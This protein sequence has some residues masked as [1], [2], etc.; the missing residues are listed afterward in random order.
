MATIVISGANRGIGLEL[1]RQLKGRGDRVIAPC[2]KSSEALEKIGAEVVEGVDVSDDVSVAKMA[3]RLKSEKIDILI[4]NAGI[5]TIESLENLDFKKMLR[6][7]DVNSLGPLRVTKAL[8]PNLQ[9]GSKVAIITSRMG[10][11]DDNGSGG[12][13][14]YRMSKV[15]VNM[16]G[17]CLANDLAARGITVAILHPG[18]V[19]TEMTGYSGIEPKESARG[20]IER[21]DSFS[22]PMSGAFFHANG[23]KLPW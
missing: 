15:A 4:N 7:F 23:E 21:I 5:L 20:L 19:S 11:I 8:L 9:S 6:Q 13:Y 18:M 16:A 10:S 14:G 1:A 3:E 17:K 22:Q 12:Y 2:R